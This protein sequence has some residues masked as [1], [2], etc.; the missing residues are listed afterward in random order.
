M[1][2]MS[3][4]WVQHALVAGRERAAIEH[5]Y[6]LLRRALRFGRRALCAAHLHHGQM[7]LKFEPD[8]LALRCPDCGAE[9]PGWRLAID[10]R[11]RSTPRLLAHRRP[12]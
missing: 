5:A 3:A 9:T 7:M 4:I 10:P 1:D 12:N 6:S 11:F 8:R 2:A